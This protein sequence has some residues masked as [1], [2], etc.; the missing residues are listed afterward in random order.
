VKSHG[1]ATEKGACC[2]EG[3]SKEECKH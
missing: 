3:E 2:K 1:A